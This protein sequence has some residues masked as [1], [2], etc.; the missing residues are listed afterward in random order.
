MRTVLVVEDDTAIRRGLCDALRFGGY[1]V[2]DAA[3]GTA[4]LA[5]ALAADV[6]LVLLD[7]LLPGRDGF[8][9]LT[10]LRRAKPA[11]PVV[12]VTAKGAE[13]DRVRGLEGGA[14]G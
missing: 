4:G 8:E 7:V 13:D 1:R 14:E 5:A 9:V 12:M 10:E 2:L 6:D 11:L 3:D